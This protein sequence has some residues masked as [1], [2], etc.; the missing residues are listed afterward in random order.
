MLILKKVLELNWVALEKRLVMRVE[1]AYFSRNDE[2]CP[3]Y[4]YVYL[5]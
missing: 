2:V 3:I 5:R 4:T 1:C